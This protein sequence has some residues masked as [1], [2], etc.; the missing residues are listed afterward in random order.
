VNKDDLKKLAALAKRNAEKKEPSKVKIRRKYDSTLLPEP[1]H[2][3][4]LRLFFRDMKKRE[5]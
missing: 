2:D 4:E 1:D 3:P 5:F